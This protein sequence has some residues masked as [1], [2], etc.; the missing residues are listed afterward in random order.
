MQG[1]MPEHQRAQL[2]TVG[3]IN[4]YRALFQE[5]RQAFSHIITLYNYHGQDDEQQQK[6]N[7]LARNMM[8]YLSDSDDRVC[9]YNTRNMA[10]FILGRIM[11][12]QSPAQ[13]DN[14]LWQLV[15]ETEEGN[16]RI[17]GDFS[18]LLSL[19]AWAWLNRIVDSATQVSI[20]CP[21]RMVRQVDARHVLEVLIQQIDP[22]ELVNI[23]EQVFQKPSSVRTSLLFTHLVAGEDYRQRM[24]ADNDIDPLL[25]ETTDD[26]VV[27]CEQLIINNWGDAHV[28][29]YRGSQGIL[30]CL[31]DWMQATAGDA[32]GVPEPIQ[33]YGYAAGI[34]TFWAQRIE[35]LFA[36]IVE[37]FHGEN[38]R[39]G[40][41][42]VRMGPE[43]YMLEFAND[44]LQPRRIGNEAAL[45]KFLE[46]PNEEFRPYGMERYAL[47]ETPL[48]A[49][50]ERN[51]PGVVQVFFQLR[52]R[53]CHTWVLDEKGSLWR[54]QQ[55][56]FDRSSYVAHWLY[57]MRNIRNRLKRINY[58]N[59]ELPSMEIQQIIGNQLGGL[60]FHA[61][62]AEAVSVE[63]GF[64]DVHLSVVGEEQGDRLSLSC[65]GREFGY[66]QFGEKAM[67]EC[68]QYI[69]ARIAGEGPGPVYITDIDV[70]LRLYGVAERDAIQ[71]S[72]FLK[73]IRTI[74]NRLNQ[75][76]SG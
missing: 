6:L 61:I 54:Q 38:N 69:T 41:F 36:E 47:T 68:V 56:W 1:A 10:E 65:D 44:T 21:S 20:D 18:N 58:Q 71:V 5:I 59:R 14:R 50:F 12:R 40:R 39:N 24:E 62:G 70:P 49:L 31:C 8:V 2:D 29:R 67:A 27:N 19:V 43:Y 35:Q 16:E 25:Y 13:D 60:D 45:F 17:L 55:R 63:R 52:N 46:L 15:M 26:L 72:H 9:I 37:F 66:Q 7:G 48:R 75:M 33:C 42:I 30:Q 22:D 4:L 51:R 3:F 28:R 23:S 34:S 76:V 32:G 74:E 57:L 73:Y 11:L 53:Y 64:F